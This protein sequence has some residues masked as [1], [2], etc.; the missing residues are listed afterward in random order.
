[1]WIAARAIAIGG[2]I[3]CRPIRT[4]HRIRIR[5]LVRNRSCFRSSYCSSGACGTAS[6]TG[7]SACGSKVGS[8]VRNRRQ[9]RN[10]KLVQQRNRRR[11][12]SRSSIRSSYC[13]SVACSSAASR[14]GG[15]FCGSKVRSSWERSRRPAHKPVHNTLAHNHNLGGDGTPGHRRRSA[16][17]RRQ[18][19]RRRLQEFDFSLGGLL[20]IGTNRQQFRQLTLTTAL[21]L[22]VHFALGAQG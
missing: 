10:R 6:R 20:N 9:V 13:S 18:P 22:P 21:S 1:M 12:R 4:S 7:G 19:I 14:T 8:K 2:A 3:D 17:H 15:I 11:V 16:S 5:K